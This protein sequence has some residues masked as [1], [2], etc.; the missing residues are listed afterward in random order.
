MTRD[1][2][3][4]EGTRVHYTTTTG[5]RP[6]QSHPSFG[7]LDNERTWRTIAECE[8]VAKEVGGT[9]PQVGTVHAKE[10]RILSACML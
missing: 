9:V 8:A 7:Q 6:I 4:P 3:A 10:T 1:G 2:G 5:R